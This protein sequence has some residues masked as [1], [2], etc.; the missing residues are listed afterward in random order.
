[1]KR[2]M[3]IAIIPEQVALIQFKAMIGNSRV[4]TDRLRGQNYEGLGIIVKKTLPFR[5]S[6]IIL[7]TLSVLLIMRE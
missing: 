3:F 5:E 6:P 1:M 4:M 7:R 2:L